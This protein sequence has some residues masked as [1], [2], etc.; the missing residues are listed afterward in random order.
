MSKIYANQIYQDTHFRKIFVSIL[1]NLR[2]GQFVAYEAT[3]RSSLFP[4]HVSSTSVVVISIIQKHVQNIKFKVSVQTLI[5]YETR[6]SD[7]DE[8][9]Q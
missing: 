1:V 2:F 8:Q 4:K 6:L 3:A 7:V 5:F 9:R